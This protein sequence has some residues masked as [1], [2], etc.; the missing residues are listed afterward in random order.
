MFA[1]KCRKSNLS[2][3]GEGIVEEQEATIAVDLSQGV[4]DGLQMSVSASSL[5]SPCHF[6][7]TQD[8]LMHFSRWVS[9]EP[10]HFDHVFCYILR[11]KRTELDQ[12]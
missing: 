7:V 2:M 10:S 5:A 11:Q 6:A 8:R 3:Y 12:K 9:R 1:R 4:S